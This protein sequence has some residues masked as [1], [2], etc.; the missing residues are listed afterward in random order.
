MQ[1]DF[2]HMVR[3]CKLMYLIAS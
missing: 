3:P 2:K 1:E